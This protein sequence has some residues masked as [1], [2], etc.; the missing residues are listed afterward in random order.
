ML[1]RQLE[2]NTGYFGLYTPHYELYSLLANGLC[3]SDTIVSI[4]LLAA[5]S[6]HDSGI[7]PLGPALRLSRTP[8]SGLSTTSTERFDVF[9]QDITPLVL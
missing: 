5:R 3:V 1:A 9:D 6:A 7:L 2:P 8:C 4:H